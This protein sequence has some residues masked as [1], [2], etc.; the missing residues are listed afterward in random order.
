MSC[1]AIWPLCI[2]HQHIIYSTQR[3]YTSMFPPLHSHMLYNVSIYYNVMWLLCIT[4]MY[5]TKSE[6]VLQ[7]SMYC[8]QMEWAVMQFLRILTHNSISTTLQL[9][10]KWIAAIAIIFQM[11]RGKVCV[12][13][14]ISSFCFSNYISDGSSDCRSFT[15][16]IISSA[17]TRGL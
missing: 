7:I 10:F 8:V 4:S 14:L 6:C 5:H 9:H 15:K 16:W 13:S 12:L 1:N 3:K 17:L 2:I 11:D